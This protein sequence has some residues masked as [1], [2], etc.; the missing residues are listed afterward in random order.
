MSLHLVDSHIGQNSKGGLEIIEVYS[1]TLIYPKGAQRPPP[2]QDVPK[3]YAEDYIEACLVLPDSPKASAALSRR[4]LQ[5]LLRFEANVKHGD[6]YGEIQQVIDSKQLPSHIAESIDA[7]RHIGNFA[8]HP[9]KS[10]ATGEII[11]VETG[12]AEWNLNVLDA[13]FDFY[14][15]QRAILSKKKDELNKKLLDAGKKPMK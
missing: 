12:E 3:K 4:C 15:V 7:I 1:E 8:A 11:K 2:S 13:L 6:L 14:F 5:H 9:Q 10:T